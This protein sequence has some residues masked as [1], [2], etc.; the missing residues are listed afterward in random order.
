[1]KTL[2]ILITIIAAVSFVGCA[3]TPEAKL[4]QAYKRAKKTPFEQLPALYVKLE[5]EEKITTATREHWTEAWNVANKKHQ[6]EIAAHE[7]EQQRLADKRRREWESLT[8]AQRYNLEMRE[9]ELQQQ[10]DMIAF[11][12]EQQRRANIQSAIQGFSNSLQHQ[13]EI[14][15]YNARTNALAQPQQLNLNH[16]GTINH[17]VYGY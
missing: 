12:A 4:N 9:R 8:P 16:S 1:M 6:K 17:N 7:K 10:Q 15:A 14:N 5:Q 13:Q 2:S 3:T 11:Q